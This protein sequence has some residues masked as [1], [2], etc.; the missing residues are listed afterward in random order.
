MS[1]VLPWPPKTLSPNARSH[2]RRKAE[3]AKK[4]K[5]DCI[6]LLRS[7]GLKS[8]NAKTAIIGILFCPPDNRRRD[9]DNMIASFKYGIDAISHVTGIDDSKFF[10][11]FNPPGDVQKPGCVHVTLAGGAA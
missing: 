2:W 1:Y 4:Y 11:T 5:G 3:A 9:P 10:L 6:A 7:Q 8:I